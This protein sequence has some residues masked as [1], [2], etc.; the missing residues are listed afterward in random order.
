[1]VRNVLFAFGADTK[2]IL[3]ILLAREQ[4]KSSLSFFQ[5][6]YRGSYAQT[7]IYSQDWMEEL[8]VQ[9]VRSHLHPSTDIY[10]RGCKGKGHSLAAERA[11]AKVL[12]PSLE[13]HLQFSETP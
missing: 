10:N 12:P 8:A 6:I 13:T 5:G 7:L 9:Q 3:Y 11:V 4:W 1:M 2:V